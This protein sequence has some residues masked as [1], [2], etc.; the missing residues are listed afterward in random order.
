MRRSFA[1]GAVALRAYRAQAIIDVV[2]VGPVFAALA[3][4][5]AALIRVLRLRS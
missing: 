3:L 2:V 4:A 5:L 1:T